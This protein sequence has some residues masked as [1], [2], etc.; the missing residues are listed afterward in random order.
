MVTKPKEMHPE[1]RLRPSDT[2]EYCCTDYKEYNF[3]KDD[4]LLAKLFGKELGEDM[5]NITDK[6]FVSLKVTS[7]DMKSVY[8]RSGCAEEHSERGCF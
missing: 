2:K 5:K 4:I 8:G 1:I 6:N 3:T 7:G